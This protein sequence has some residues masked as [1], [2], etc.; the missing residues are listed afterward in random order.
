MVLPVT[1]DFFTDKRLFTKYLR[2]SAYWLVAVVLL[3]GAGHL[4]LASEQQSDIKQLE[5]HLWAYPD[6][7][8]V[9]AVGPNGKV[10]RHKIF[11]P[12]FAG[13]MTTVIYQLR[14]CAVEQRIKQQEWQ[15][16]GAKFVVTLALGIDKDGYTNGLTLNTNPSKT[17]PACFE[18]VRQMARSA[19]FTEDAT[20]KIVKGSATFEIVIL[21]DADA[22][23]RGYQFYAAER[24]FERRLRENSHWF[25][26]SSDADCTIVKT[27]CVT[28]GVNK[29][30]TEAFSK[31]LL[32][33]P[34]PS[35]RGERS[36]DSQVQC[37]QKV[38]TIA[39]P[40]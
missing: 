15:A 22:Q 1:P 40:R 30:F 36:T 13:L 17:A 27:K 33:R 2:Y 23:G 35:C 26:C 9:S 14:V 37:R 24:D 19:R 28:R 10:A 8:I 25:A 32:E 39:R 31:A 3:A 4:S 5:R 12:E 29:L 21:S 11:K 16:H 34:T 6:G 7:V 18:A 20:E 38:C